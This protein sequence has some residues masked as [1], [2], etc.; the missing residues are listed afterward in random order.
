MTC[1]T[2]PGI[3]CLIIPRSECLAGTCRDPLQRLVA[4]LEKLKRSMLVH[5]AQLKFLLLP[6]GFLKKDENSNISM[7]GHRESCAY[8]N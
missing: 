1:K 5:E 3:Q 6:L 2:L 8:I 4:V 7:R